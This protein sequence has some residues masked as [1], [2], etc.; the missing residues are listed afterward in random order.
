M[1]ADSKKAVLGNEEGIA[2][3]VVMVLST[4]ALAIMAALIYMT[5]SGTQISGMQKRYATAYEAGKG[6]AE[7]VY[8]VIGL[9]GGDLEAAMQS[10]LSYGM[11]TPGTCITFAN[12]TC[13][14][15]GNYTMLT[16]KLMLPTRCWDGCDGGLSIDVANPTS[17]DMQFDVGSNPAYRVYAKIVDTQEGNVGGDE[18]LIQG[19]VVQSTGE[20]SVVPQS[21]YYTIEMR[22]S[23]RD[24]DESKAERSKISVL[25]QF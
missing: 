9:R 15:I 5:T 1:A 22:A 2:L 24:I 25:Y 18:D 14:G 17:Y 19:G 16:T 3:M 4:I 12:T 11:T 8:R 10:N 13:L 21:F 6:G 7:V 20:V 23:N